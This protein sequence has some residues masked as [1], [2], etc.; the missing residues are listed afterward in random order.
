[1]AMSA[2]SD[3]DFDL[4]DEL[5][6]DFDLADD[7]DHEFDLADDVEH[8]MDH[9]P[10]EQPFEAPLA[11]VAPAAPV[12]PIDQ[13]PV[14]HAD[15]DL[16]PV[17]PVPLPDHDPIFDEIPDIAPILPDPVLMFDDYAPFATHIDPRYAD[18]H[19]GWVDDDDYPPYVRPVTPSHAPISAPIDVAPH[20]P[21]VS[22][23]HRTDLPITFLHDI[24]PP[25]P[26]EGSSRQQP[27]FVPPVSSAIP[28][29]S[30]FPR[31]TSPF[32]PMGEPFLWSI[33]Q[34]YASIRPISPVSCRLYHR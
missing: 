19:N 24:P 14:V 9:A 16:A 31:T 6:H 25:R 4:A 17:D 26:G 23:I 3:N 20:F 15:L 27:A 18:T 7:P 34:C 33:A 2:A 12:A 28:F 21:R 8:G 29:T 13:P 22:D 5:D 10:E 30:Q 32:A 11:P 1:M